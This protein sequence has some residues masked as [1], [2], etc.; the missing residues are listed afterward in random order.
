[1]LPTKTQNNTRQTN[2]EIIVKIT[3]LQPYD[4][5]HLIRI[6]SCVISIGASYIFLDKY[7]RNILQYYSCIRVE[8]KVHTN[9]TP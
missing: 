9:I 6:K 5:M 3:A 8:V 4:C 1:M 2:T 7:L